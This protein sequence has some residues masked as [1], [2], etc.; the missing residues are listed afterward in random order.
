[1]NKTLI[2]SAVALSAA[3]V[4]LTAVAYDGGMQEGWYMSGRFGANFPEDTKVTNN[5]DATAY[6]TVEGKTGY[7]FSGAVGY[8]FQGFRLEGEAGYMYDNVHRTVN[9]AGTAQTAPGGNQKLW[10]GLISAYYDFDL[11]NQFFPYIGAGAGMAKYRNEVHHSTGNIANGME[12]VFAYQGTLGLGYQVNDVL[13]A[14]VDYRYTATN[15][16]DFEYTTVNSTAAAKYRSNS[17]N[18]GLRYYF[19]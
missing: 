17:I 8:G 2:L 9:Q 14:T 13:A 10:L 15:N 16:G 4:S 1:M 5:A 7:D 19:A 11:G 3:L 6:H 12:S 18:F